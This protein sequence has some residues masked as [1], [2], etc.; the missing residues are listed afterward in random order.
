MPLTL[1]LRDRVHDADGLEC[2]KE[3]LRNRDVDAQ[4]AQL[5]SWLMA[6]NPADRPTA[7]EVWC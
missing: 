2:P 7:R 4:V 5:V 1:A 6:A 3:T